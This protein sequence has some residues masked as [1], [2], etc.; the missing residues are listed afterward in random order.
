MEGEWWGERESEGSGVRVVGG[1][2]SEGS[3]GRVVMGVGE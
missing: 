1:E 3:G 2:G